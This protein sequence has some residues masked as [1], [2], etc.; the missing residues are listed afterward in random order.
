VGINGSYN[1]L[2]IT[3]IGGSLT[4]AAP[5]ASPL[6]PLL[7][8]RGDLRFA[9]ELQVS[10]PLSVARDAWFAESATVLAL[11]TIGRDVHQVP[12]K[13]LDES[14]SRGTNGQVISEAFTVAPPCRCDASQV[15]DWTTVIAG[16]ALQNDN[17][18]IGLTTAAL[19]QPAG[20]IA[21]T[22]PCGS[23]Y[24]DGIASAGDLH[25]S[26]VGRVALFVAGD[27][28]ASAQLSVQLATGAE[29]DWFIGGQLDLATTTAQVGDAERPAALRIYVAG[30]G[31]LSVPSDYVFANLYAPRSD[32]AL[33]GKADFYGSI[34]GQT[35]SSA[36]SISV[37]YDAAVQRVAEGCAPDEPPSCNGCGQCSQGRACVA[38]GCAACSADSDCCWPLICEGGRC[39]AFNE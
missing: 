30:E 16:A 26:V 11:A 29:L 2:S 21:L 15:M 31:Q 22:L 5:T 14:I 8:V 38:G 3:L 34:F 4:V 37:H 24:L 19:I 10:G 28:L 12:G 36:K 35:V 33:L 20:A 9:G 27:V 17:P 23:F 1:T 13:T 39:T 25:L 6:L 18:S 32:V 7:D